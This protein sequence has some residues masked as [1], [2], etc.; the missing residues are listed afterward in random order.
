M[1]PLFSIILPTFCAEA[2]VLEALESIRRQTFTDYEIVVVD[3]GST[4]KTLDLIA[5]GQAKFEGRLTFHSE[6]DDGIYDAMN[7]GISRA[8][9]EWIYFLGADD[10]L[11]DP[12]V[13]QNV[14]AFIQ[15]RPDGHLI[16]GDVILHS[17]SSRYAGSFDL[18]KLLF[19][20]NICHQAIFYRRIVFEKLGG[21]NLRYRIWADWDL[22]IRCFQ[23][24][25]FI[26]NHVDLVIADYNDLSGKSA[27][28]DPILR[29]Q[30]PV[31]IKDDM[32]REKIR[33]RQHR[34]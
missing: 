33:A 28:E 21:Y 9:G 20:K 14:A 7:K 16:Y 5:G 27:V 32:E 23:H 4:D 26:Q 12:N 30:L 34:F 22:N 25:A 24:P 1:K 8:Q 15:S 2:V 3:G 6:K 17:N 18:D 10:R 13:L 11:H 19:E 31:I 29:K